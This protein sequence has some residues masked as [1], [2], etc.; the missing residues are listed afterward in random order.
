MGF[1]DRIRGRDAAEQGPDAENVAGSGGGGVVDAVEPV[2]EIGIRR[3]T[4]EEEA[5]LD[6]ARTGYAEHGIDPAELA[7]VAAAYAET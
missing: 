2:E 6:R 5:A 4:A 3:L 1:L 7:T